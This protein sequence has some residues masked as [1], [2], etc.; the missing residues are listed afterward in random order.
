M[1]KLSKPFTMAGELRSTDIVAVLAPNKDGEMAV[2]PMIWGFSHKASDA[3]IVNCRLE[4]AS[5]ISL[6][7]Y[8]WKGHFYEI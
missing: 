7:L 3:P 6:M 2:F 8:I 1:L 5:S 4:S